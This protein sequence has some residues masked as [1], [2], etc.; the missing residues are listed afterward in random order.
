MTQALC[1]RCGTRKFGALLACSR[2]GAAPVFPVDLNLLF[3][4]HALAVSTLDDFGQALVALAAVCLDGGPDGGTDHALPM[5]CFLHWVAQRWPD[6]LSIQL[7]A[8]ER[9]ALDALIARAAL[10][11]VK[12]V[13]AGFGRL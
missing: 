5:K 4:D 9:L 8:D 3:S 11:P 2:C 10:P 12:V 13:R 7:Q 1:L 6:L